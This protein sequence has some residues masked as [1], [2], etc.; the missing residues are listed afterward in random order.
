MDDHVDITEEWKELKPVFAGMSARGS[1]P[2]DKPFFITELFELKE[3]VDPEVLKEAWDKTL[4]AY[5][6]MNHA[7]LR[8]ENRFVLT[9]NPLPFVIRESDETITPSCK[10]SNHHTVTFGYFGNRLWVYADHTAV[11]GTGLKMVLE[12]LFY[13]YFCIFDKTEYPVPEGV[14]TG[15]EGAVPGQDV[16]AYLTAE[17]IEGDTSPAYPEAFFEFPEAEK[18]KIFPDGEACR[19]YCILIPG[20]KFISYAKNI[21]ASPMSM[22]A[23][24]MAETIQRVNPKNILP[25]PMASPVSIRKVIGNQNS[26]L[27]QVLQAVY[28]FDPVNLSM[29]DDTRL[30]MDYREFLKVFASEESVLL[31]CAR[32][33]RI[34]KGYYAALDTGTLDGMI[35][36][37]RARSGGMVL[38]SY[39]GTLKA[40]EYGNRIK[41]KVLH[42]LPQR[43]IMV[44]TMEA[45]DTFCI[46]WYQGFTDEVYVNTFL[47]ILKEIGDARLERI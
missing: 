7:V 30:N 6:Y 45:G 36:K 4:M 33:K 41:M 13:H 34:I 40:G 14:F 43:G 47:E 3:R 15:K 16:D 9:E 28:F 11:D 23:V 21:G 29:E 10:D 27:P 32:Y 1:Y 25:I 20:R 35:L 46:C 44:Q 22:L 17:T 18:D 37:N 12:T 19:S 39:L 26:L 8:R 31:Q 38:N 42:V 24:L 5:P 2:L